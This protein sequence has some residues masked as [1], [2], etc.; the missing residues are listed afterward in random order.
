MI[1]TRE[2]AVLSAEVATLVI[3][4][5]SCALN[6]GPRLHE[7]RES[8][9]GEEGVNDLTRSLACDDVPRSTITS[10]ESIE[11]MYKLRG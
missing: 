9:N 8:K 11:C 2:Q 4:C 7:W 1:F 5:T 6:T 10:R 3:M